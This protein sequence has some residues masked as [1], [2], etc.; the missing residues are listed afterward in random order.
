MLTLALAGWGVLRL[1]AALGTTAR[2]AASGLAVWNPFVVERMALGQWALVLAYAALPWVV[3]ASG[4]PSPYGA[5][6]ERSP[7]AVLWSALASLTAD[8]GTV[9]AGR[10]RR[11]R[12]VPSPRGPGG[13]CW[14]RGAPPA[15]LGRAVPGQGGARTTSDPAGVSVFA[16]GS[17]A[18]GHPALALLGLGGIWDGL[19]VPDCGTPPLAVAAIVVV[20]ASVVLGTRHWW[21]LTP[22]LAPRLAALGVVGLLLALALTTGVGQDLLRHAVTSVPGTGLLRDGQK[23]L[24]P[25]VLL[26]ACPLGAAVDVLSRA[27]SRWGLEVVVSVGLLL[28]LVPIALVPDGAGLVWR[29]V[30]PIP[31]PAALDRVASTVDDGPPDRALV[32]LPW[33]SYRNFAWGTGYPSSDP[34]VRMVDRPVITSD[35][36][37]VGDRAS[38]GRAPQTTGS[39]PRSTGG[40]LPTRSRASA[41]AGSWSTPT[42]LRRARSTCP[43]C[44]GSSP[45]PS[46]PCTPCPTRSARPPRPRGVA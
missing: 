29:T 39:V 8:R 1:T 3:L 15:A 16:P 42:T 11:R 13:S 26:V 23:L 45:P 30:Q 22:D 7:A 24:A 40:D 17:D 41:S 12:S 2:L 10:R 34:L 46:S 32:T 35:D 38:T 5:R 14:H 9:R 18:A 28:V 43:A 44:A 4:D 21:R 25:F 6:A 36:L 27:L 37:V 20:V 31:F 33:R 19:S